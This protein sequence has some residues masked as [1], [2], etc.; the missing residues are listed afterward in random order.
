MGFDNV[1]PELLKAILGGN[2]AH[3]CNDWM[4]LI[5]GDDLQEQ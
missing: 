3:Y 2:S 4:S 1:L 5:Y